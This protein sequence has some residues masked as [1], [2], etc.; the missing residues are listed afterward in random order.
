MVIHPPSVNC[1]LSILNHSPPAPS[2]AGWNVS[3]TA[4]SIRLQLVDLAEVTSTQFGDGTAQ[5]S[6]IDKLVITFQGAVD[7]DAGAFSVW[8]RG[9][10]GGT[11][12]TSF[13]LSADGSGNTVATLSFSGAFTR[14]NGALID[15]YYQLTIDNSRVR[16]AGTQLA[17]DGNGDG[18]AGGDFV[19]GTSATD[20]FFAFYGDTNGDGVVGVAE[21]GEFRSTFGKLP[22][23]PGYNLL[24]DYDGS[25]VGV[26]D[27]GQFR[28]RFGRAI[29]FE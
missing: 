28:S 25:G 24:M 19:R 21:F 23:D 10:G 4:N 17:L 29:V 9:V 14:A 22:G 1:S 3:K 15:G 18:L 5:R 12:A 2:G 7:I 6:R 11:V 16:R 13:V 27:F 8:R 26:A 20:K